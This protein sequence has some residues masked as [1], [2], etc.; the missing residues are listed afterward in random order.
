MDPGTPYDA[1]ALATLQMV[2]HEFAGFQGDRSR[3]VMQFL[4]CLT[5]VQPFDGSRP[6][7]PSRIDVD[8]LGTGQS[9]AAITCEWILDQMPMLWRYLVVL[10]HLQEAVQGRMLWEMLRVS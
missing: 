7:T 10:K 1:K 6:T 4:L 5:I 8:I 3:Q 2:M 9:S